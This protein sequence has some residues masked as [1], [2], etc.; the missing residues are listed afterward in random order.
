MKN[1][2]PLEKKN[3]MLE[4]NIGAGKSTF[5]RILEPHINANAIF[6]P[7]DKWQNIG[8]GENLLDL[9]Y[10]DIKR[11]AYTFQSYA[12]I[13]RIQAFNQLKPE[14]TD[15]P[16]KVMERSVYCDRYCFAK[17]CFEMGLMSP[18]EWQIYK[19]WFSWLAENYAPQPAGFIYLQTNP[20]ICF[21]RLKKRN[22]SEETGVSL[23]YLKTL[24]ERHEDWLIAKK[25]IDNSI[26]ATPLLIIDCNESFEN[27][28]RRQKEIITQV[29]NFMDQIQQNKLITPE[30]NITKNALL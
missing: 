13:S 7:T 11:W 3:L 15:K 25:D 14:Q 23:D 6:E 20:E 27:N 1:T 24:H 16:F 8:D 9:F 10:K 12:F 17:N 22:R 26:K 28:P 29:N 18:L 2:I 5:L 4:G 19:D 21:E 30:Q